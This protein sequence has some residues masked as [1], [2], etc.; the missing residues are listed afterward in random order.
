MWRDPQSGYRRRN[1]SPSAWPSPIRIVEVSFPPGATVAYET[2]GRELEIHQQVWVLSG[3]IEVTVGLDTH[4]L[5]AGDCLAIRVDRPVTFR[6]R[7]ARSARYGV[8]QVV[9]PAALR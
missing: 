8:V 4:R 7:A 3:R 2:A 9:E 5:S 6:N 1:V